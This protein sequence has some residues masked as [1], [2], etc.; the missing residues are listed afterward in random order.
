MRISPRVSPARIDSGITACRDS[1]ITAWHVFECNKPTCKH[2]QYTYYQY[3]LLS[4]SVHCY[5]RLF[6]ATQTFMLLQSRMNVVLMQ[7]GALKLISFLQKRGVAGQ[8]NDC[9]MLH[10]CLI[11]A[12][13]H[14]QCEQLARRAT[15]NISE[16][17]V[18]Q[19]YTPAHSC[20]KPAALDR[21]HAS[22]ASATWHARPPVTILPALWRDAM[23]T[24]SKTSTNFLGM[25]HA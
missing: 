17:H 15:R 5:R 21:Q 24:D 20:V 1:G 11:Y 14:T 25:H 18:A 12:Y 2:G 6:A 7:W 22:S 13:Q 16:C 4:S 23:A 3:V 8:H 19:K 9:E 10:V